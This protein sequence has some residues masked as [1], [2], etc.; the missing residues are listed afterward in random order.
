MAVS[1]MSSGSLRARF[2]PPALI[3]RLNLYRQVKE[4]ELGVVSEGNILTHC[5]LLEAQAQDIARK[6]ILLHRLGR[7]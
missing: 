6:A 7:R 2:G 3:C 4:A 5:S 1:Q